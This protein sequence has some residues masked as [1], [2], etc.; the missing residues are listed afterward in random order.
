V[1]SQQDSKGSETD[2]NLD[3]I[4]MC[5]L[6]QSYAPSVTSDDNFSTD[7]SNN[8]SI[9]YADQ[10]HPPQALMTNTFDIMDFEAPL[11]Q[12]TFLHYQ[13]LNQ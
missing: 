10:E 9:I 6:D 13:Q 12:Q 4:S 7:T 8:L 3:T 5:S 11:S 2:I 1:D